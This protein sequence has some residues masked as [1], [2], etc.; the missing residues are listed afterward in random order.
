MDLLDM[1][2]RGMRIYIYFWSR[3]T[4]LLH[5]AQKL[6]KYPVSDL[7]VCRRR[8]YISTYLCM[9]LSDKKNDFFCIF[10]QKIV[11]TEVWIYYSLYLFEYI[12]KRLR[13][14]RY[15]S[16]TQQYLHVWYLIVIWGIFTQNILWTLPKIQMLRYIPSANDDRGI[17][18]AIS[19][20][21][22][23]LYFSSSRP[24]FFEYFNLLFRLFN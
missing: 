21:T 13:T 5:T 19:N 7:N 11:V 6:S 16:D 24:D 10:F 14:R 12:K 4:C 2:D 17:C 15:F 8:I 9:L 23:E 3:I 18:D 20:S 22:L 1:F